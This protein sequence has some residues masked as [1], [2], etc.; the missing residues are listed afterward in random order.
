MNQLRITK[1][2]TQ[3]YLSAEVNP[4]VRIHSGETIT[5]ETERADSMYIQS[6][7]DVFYSFEDMLKKQGG[8]TN[9]C[10]GPIY[11]EEAEPGDRLSVEILKITPTSVGYTC[12]YPGIGGLGSSTMDPNLQPDLP[13]RTTICTIEKSDVLFPV[14]DRNIAIPL[15]PFIGTLAT[16]PAQQKIATFFNGREFLGNVDCPLLSPG[17]TVI[18]PVNVRGGL[19]FMGDVHAAQGH[20]EICGTAIECQGEVILRVSVLKKDE[21]TYISWPQINNNDYIGSIACVSTSLEDALKAA[22]IDMILRLEAGG[23]DRLDA[24]QL[25]TQIGEVLVCQSVP[26]LYTCVVKIR[27]SYSE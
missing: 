19:I 3:F 10:S 22:Y 12:L 23:F 15:N 25:I 4:A 24:Y 6:S 2:F 20:G 1:E 18:L 13:P 17:N 5:V 26:P 27:R 8:G 21:I 9:P 14:G 11:I 7:K 16:A